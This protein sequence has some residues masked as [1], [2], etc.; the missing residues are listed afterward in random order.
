MYFKQAING[1]FTFIILTLSILLSSNIAL[2][3]EDDGNVWND[4]KL[5]SSDDPSANIDERLIP[6][7][8]GPFELGGFFRFNLTDK[9]WDKNYDTS[10]ELELD[11]VGINVNLRNT[12]PIIGSFQY[13]FYDPTNGGD[14]DYHFM[15]HGWLGYKFD[16]DNTIKVGVH[17]VPF[18][19]DAFASNSWFFQLPYY[20]GLE[21]DY[22]A[23]IKY[24]HTIGNW[25]HEMAYYLCDEGQYYGESRDSARYSYDVVKSTPGWFG[26]EANNEERNQFNYRIS[27]QMEH[28][29]SWTSIIGS[30]LQYSQIHNTVN[31]KDGNHYAAA[32]HIN[33]SY[34]P[35]NLKAEVI[36]Y[37]YSLKNSA[38]EGDGSY[39]VMGAYD[40]PYRVASRANLYCIGINR[41]FNVN[42]GLISN[43]TVYNDYT[44]M[45]KDNSSFS[46]TQHN[47][48][49]FSMSI[50][51]IITYFDVLVGKNHPWAGPGWSDSLAAGD[52]DMSDWYTRVNLNVGYYF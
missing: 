12:G 16:D 10:G 50:G 31:G 7:T 43:I 5:G 15:H 2:A 41:S 17:Q 22:D 3:Q 23:G 4:F 33:S 36:R 42:W 46:D 13:R 21:D 29:E 32:A 9:D 27:Y 38:S 37:E 20:V 19:V 48:T 47:V 6:I 34:G 1:I 24:K 51:R 45:D 40:Y 44:F 25:S 49:G 39:V 28:S 35:Y 30:S 8:A 18:G 52:G 26:E 14:Y 11:V